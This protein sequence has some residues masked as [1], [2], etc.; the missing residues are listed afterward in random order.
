MT[1]RASTSKEALEMLA[2]Q[3]KPLLGLGEWTVRVDL[4]DFTRSWQQGDVKV[5]PVAKEA[6]ILMARTPFRNEEQTLL[7]ELV[8]VVLWP[9]DQACMDLAEGVGEPGSREQELAKSMVFRALEPVT[10]Q[11]TQA[12]LR[13][14]GR[15]VHHAWR[16]LEEEAEPRRKQPL[17]DRDESRF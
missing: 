17:A 15:Q 1:H 16:M 14:S 11:V 3:W 7:H 10:E 5:D 8:H 13:A 9:L 12:L 2:E 4:V 6:L